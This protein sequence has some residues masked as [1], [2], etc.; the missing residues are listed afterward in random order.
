LVN[1][2]LFH[3][4]HVNR[5]TSRQVPVTEDDLLGTF[6]YQ[7]VNVEY[8]VNHTQDSVKGRLDGVAPVYGDVSVQDFL[9]NFGISDQPSTLD[10]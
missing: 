4:S 1:P 9:Q 3:H 8:L 7:L 5:V 10:S 6:D 2:I